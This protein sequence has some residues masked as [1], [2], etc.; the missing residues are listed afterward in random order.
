MGEH[1]TTRIV[2]FEC[3]HTR[4]FPDPAPKMGELLWCLR[5]AREVKVIRGS[6]EWRVRCMNC[7]YSRPFGA[8]KVNAEI[9]AAKHR[10]SHTDHVVGLY[11]GI[12]LVR[13]F[14]D[15]SRD[16]NQTVIPMTSDSDPEIP[17]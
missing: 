7:I 15:E 2:E 8:A 12:T 11:N 16:R 17:F 10:M 13:R 3:H 4:V 9:A 14:P 1:K 6:L 5:C